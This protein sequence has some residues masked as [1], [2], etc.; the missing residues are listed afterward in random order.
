M[1]PQR[2]VRDRPIWLL[3]VLLIA[4]V[5]LG[6]ASSYLLTRSVDKNTNKVEATC[7]AVKDTRSLFRAFFTPSAQ[8]KGGDEREREFAQRLLVEIP[9]DCGPINFRRL[10]R[11]LEE[12]QA[13]QR[14]KEA[15]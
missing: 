11:V 2:L 15:R 3:V 8:L 1:S 12:A 6:A 9:A 14:A 4:A 13:Y 7:D 10:N 5:G